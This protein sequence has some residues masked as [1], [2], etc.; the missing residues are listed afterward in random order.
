MPTI[1][2]RIIAGELPAHKV[3][4]T[5]DYLAFL[6]IR[7][8]AVGHTLVVPKVEVDYIFDLADDHL[9][10]LLLF[11]KKVARALEATVPCQRIGVA[12]IGLE[13]P[14][15]HVHLVPLNSMS[16]MLQ[17]GKPPIDLSAEALADWAAK[18]SA[19]YQ[20]HFGR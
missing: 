12:V 14:H 10:G 5:A 16:D 8:V 15:A 17:F 6:D 20:A 3:A 1:F 2:S 9:S 4:E 13:V 11:A 18:I 19:I 7:P